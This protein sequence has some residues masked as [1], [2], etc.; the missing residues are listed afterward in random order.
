MKF[1]ATRNERGKVKVLPESFLKC[2]TAADRKA[3]GQ[4]SAEE[5]ILAFSAKSERKLQG[6]IVQ[7]LRLNGIEVLW[8]RTDKRSAATVGWPDLT[9]CVGLSR[10][11]PCAWEVKLHG[12]LSKEQEQMRLR[13]IS[14]PNLWNYRVIRSVDEALEELRRMGVK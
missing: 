9:F 14:P 5:A 1:N 3:I 11:W 12:L 2:M 10:A 7:L 6:Q 4:M 13:L 8:H